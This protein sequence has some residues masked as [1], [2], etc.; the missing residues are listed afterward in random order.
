MSYAPYPNSDQFQENPNV[1]CSN[2]MINWV[3]PPGVTNPL[4]PTPTGVN[5]NS[6][7]GIIYN[8]DTA[9]LEIWWRTV[10]VGSPKYEI[11]YRITSSDGITWSAPQQCLSTINE[12]G[13]GLGASDIVHL[14]ST[15]PVY[16]NGIYRFYCCYAQQVKYFESTDALNWTDKGYITDVSSARIGGWHIGLFY[17]SEKSQYEILVATGGSISDI[18][19][20]LT[21]WISSDGVTNWTQT[22]FFMLPPDDPNAWDHTGIYRSQLVYDNENHKY[23]VVYSANNK[24]GTVK[25]WQLGLCI[26]E[27]DNIMTMKGTDASYKHR[28]AK[29]TRKNPMANIGDVLFDQTLN[30]IIYCKDIDSNRNRIWV[31]SNGAVV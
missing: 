14:D 29:P 1:A 9:K 11:I 8:P 12:L 17:N 20:M 30:K 2:D 19:G 23:Y 4:Y 18:G 28:M 24:Y 26:S 7:T 27:D 13:T 16:R 6:D 22:P 5:Y 3:T 31:D 10:I 21:H 25:E 15:S